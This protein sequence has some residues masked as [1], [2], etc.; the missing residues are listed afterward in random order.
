MGADHK[1]L[2]DETG[3]I[4]ACD[5]SG[6]PDQCPLDTTS[7]NG[8]T[9]TIADGRVLPGASLDAMVRANLSTPT[10]PLTSLTLAAADRTGAGGP[11]V[12]LI[13]FSLGQ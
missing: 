2:T 11:L 8:Y 12:L 7:L 1:L 3:R 10:P 13:S 4:V 6:V 5:N 9:A